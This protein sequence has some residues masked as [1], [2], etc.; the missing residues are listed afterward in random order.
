[1]YECHANANPKEKQFW[2]QEIERIN[3]RT[4]LDR[5]IE[6]SLLYLH[7]FRCK[8]GVGVSSRISPN[9]SFSI[10]IKVKRT[11]TSSWISAIGS[12]AFDIDTFCLD[13]YFKACNL[14]QFGLVCLIP[15]QK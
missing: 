8:L 5:L 1:M 13:A 14:K 12:C 6:T 7:S 9:F 4:M 10:G 11:F 3:A 2:S 15:P